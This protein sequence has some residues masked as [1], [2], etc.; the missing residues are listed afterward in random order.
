MRAI[1]LY[2][3]VLS[4]LAASAAGAGTSEVGVSDRLA[5]RG[6]IVGVQDW[7]GDEDTSDFIQFVI[8]SE[9]SEHCQLA[10]RATLRDALRLRRIRS[11]T[12]ATP[13]Q[14][15]GLAETL[16][17][18]WFLSLSLFES[19]S[20]LISQITVGADLFR[21]GSGK[22]NWTAIESATSLDDLTWFGIGGE[23]N[24]QDLARAVAVR[25]VEDLVSGPREP[26]RKPRFG[27][28]KTGFL[29]DPPPRVPGGRVAVIPLNT[30]ADRF[31]NLSAGLATATLRAVAFESGFEILFPGVV[32][33]ALRRQG[34]YQ[35]GAASEPL[36]QLLREEEETDWVLTGTVETFDPRHRSL[37]GPWI[38]FSS[39]LV[40]TE[41]GQ[42]LWS[43]GAE[44]EGADS[45]RAFQQGIIVS[46]GVLMKE[47]MRSLLASLNEVR[48]G[49]L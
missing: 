21:A 11:I 17:I 23:M 42:I 45:L 3:V 8:R 14:L 26:R 39:R 47:M 44:R 37:S 7:V 35:L 27:A 31:A 36:R 30:V 49:A 12:R 29:R 5:G 18:D 20:D 13:A 22:L 4:T 43:D 48:R 19:K 15:L 25:L 32:L 34:T 2:V 9:L 41:S 6:I 1:P 38:A 46:S 33:D 28:S 16:E 10:D 40:D 24:L